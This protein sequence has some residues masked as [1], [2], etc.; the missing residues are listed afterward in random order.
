MAGRYQRGFE[1]PGSTAVEIETNLIGP[2]PHSRTLV[3]VFPTSSFDLDTDSTF[4]VAKGVEW[5]DP[6]EK[7]V[8]KLVNKSSASATV[9]EKIQ[10]ATAYAVN[11]SDVE[12]MLLFKEP[13]L[14]DTSPAA[15]RRIP[16]L[17][18]AA[19]TDHVPVDVA[20][21]VMGQLGPETRKK[22]VNLLREYEQLFPLNSHLVGLRDGRPLAFR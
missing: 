4:G 18:R 5:W 14:E 22:V 3:L 16:E 17:P 7:F 1:I 21:A 12:R 2:I 10:V 8:L 6:K 19:P 13:L 15:K 20:T 11:T 9:H